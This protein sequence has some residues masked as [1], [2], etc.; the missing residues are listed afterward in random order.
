[1]GPFRQGKPLKLPTPE[2]DAYE[3][4]LRA[5]SHRKVTYAGIGVVVL[6][7]PL[8][9]LLFQAIVPDL[10][11]KVQNP[12]HTPSPAVVA[13]GR[14]TISRLRESAAREARARRGAVELTSLIGDPIARCLAAAFSP[15]LPRRDRP[16][17]RTWRAASPLA[18][19][20][21]CA[22]RA[23]QVHLHPADPP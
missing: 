3:A 9:A 13:N 15:L 14:A 17:R 19:M 23:R 4:E 16:P 6:T 22:P 21:T 18:T 20:E 2:L 7:L 8:L 11:Y 5:R 1:M 10:V 12:L